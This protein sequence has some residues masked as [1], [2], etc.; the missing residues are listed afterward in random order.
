MRF[1]VETSSLYDNASTLQTEMHL[2]PE[3]NA[4]TIDIS[5]KN[6]DISHHF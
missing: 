1:F 2:Y 5:H 4:V 3:R 6:L